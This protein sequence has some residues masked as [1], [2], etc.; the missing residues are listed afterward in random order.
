MN[1]GYDICE[2]G[3]Y[4]ML[5]FLLVT[6]CLLL[7]LISSTPVLA[8]SKGQVEASGKQWKWSNGEYFVPQLVMYAGPNFIKLNP[9]RVDADLQEFLTGH[10]FTG[11]HV[12]VFCS[13]Y[14]I[15]STSCSSSDN[16]ID[17]ETF[18]TLKDFIEK[19]NNQGGMVHLWLWGDS[20]RNQNPRA[21][22][23]DL[24]TEDRKILDALKY[25][26]GNT[27]GW[28]IGYGYDLF[29]WTTKTDL[30]QWYAYA[31]SIGLNNILGARGN[32]NS[33][34]LT[35]SENTMKYYSYEVH[36]P[37]YDTALISNTLSYIAQF[38]ARTTKPV[39]SE[40]RFRIRTSD[41]G[42][43][44]N[45]TQTR[46]GMWHSVMAGGVANIWGNLSGTHP[47]YGNKCDAGETYP[48]CP[49]SATAK[50][51]LKT[52]SLFWQNRYLQGM[53]VRC[54]SLTSG[55][56]LTDNT[57]HYVLYQEDTNAITFSAPVA[58]LPIAAVNTTTAYQT[59]SKGNTV[60]GT[61]TISL[62]TTTDWAV[63]IGNFPGG[64]SPTAS[65]TPTN[66]PTPAPLSFTD[67][68]AAAGL[69]TTTGGHGIMWADA[70]NNGYPD[71]FM[72][73]NHTAQGTRPNLLLINNGNKNFTESAVSRGVY[74]AD[75]SSPTY[76]GGGSHGGSWADLNNNGYYDLV[77]G[78]T[79]NSTLNKGYRNVMLK[80]NGQGFFT[81]VTP[82]IFVTR[83]EYTRAFISLDIN[84]NGKLDLFGVTDYLGDNDPSGD[85][86][87][88]YLNQGNVSFTAL[89]QGGLYDV[90]VGQGATDTDFNQDGLTDIIAANRGGQVALMKN[91]G[92]GTF[93]QI[94]PSSIGLTHNTG[95]GGDGITTADINNNGLLDILLTK[96]NA[97]KLFKNNG[98]GTY[99]LHQTFSNTNGYMGGF[100]D[101]NH[102]GFVDLVF[103]G[104]TKIY[105]NDGQGNFS[106]GPSV[107]ILGINDPRGMAFA[108]ID[109]D[110]D[111]DFAIGAKGGRSYL[112]QNNLNGGNWLKIKLISP[113]GQAGAF[114]SKVYIYPAGQLH[115][116]ILG[117]REAKS[118][119]GYLG[120]D[121]PILHFG[122]GQHLK[123]DIKVVFPDK[124]VITQFGV[125]RNQLVMIDGKTGPTPPPSITLSIPTPISTS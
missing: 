36:K 33:L 61:Q 35:H 46:Q 5:R 102:N 115:Q 8:Q 53:T 84:Q 92:D 18:T 29:E 118:N 15:N 110:G 68:S 6:I 123:V 59:V 37:M 58:G 100:A 48:S 97:G 20:S 90:R 4:S 79:Y 56:C 77:V 72:P 91:N 67:I 9:A 51:W 93:T 121:D 94:T 13:W 57:N 10:G 74:N 88:V 27:P 38:D 109:N 45:E 124:S 69:P 99:T 32:K 28:T 112:I 71:L 70:T 125:N 64:T 55:W 103:S 108:D 11:I 82:S 66:Q 44:Y 43:D 21:V 19:V 96:D 41:T 104:D 16:I 3:I 101:L 80:N 106:A 98:N 113:Q 30:D 2:T 22:G 65:P 26:L 23:F 119:Y 81:D 85:K 60:S 73:L 31:Q 87:E 111:L 117:F 105:L 122:L 17:P 86:N 24:A 25:Y 107:P 62:P 14:R 34:N 63:A 83:N 76:S 47:V 49:Y 54:N 7:S 120:Q 40:D 39:F 42:K 78:V 116:T 114:G 52:H 95:D 75:S 50:T 1:Q 12:P 89:T